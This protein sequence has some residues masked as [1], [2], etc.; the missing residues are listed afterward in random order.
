MTT[1][2]IAA[3]SSSTGTRTKLVADSSTPQQRFVEQLAMTRLTLAR[4][5]LADNK[6]DEARALLVQVA[7]DLDKLADGG[8]L[9]PRPLFADERRHGFFE[10]FERAGLGPRAQ[11]IR[12][13]LEKRH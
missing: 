8:F 10:V 11:A 7:D 4:L 12:E 13:A 2:P 5:L 9:R 1:W 3:S 6:A